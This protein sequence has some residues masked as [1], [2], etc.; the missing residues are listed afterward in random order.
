VPVNEVFA[1]TQELD[2]YLDH[3]QRQITDGDIDAD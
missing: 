3:M 1:S 2:E